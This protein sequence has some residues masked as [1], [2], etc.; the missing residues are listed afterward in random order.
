MSDRRL[1]TPRLDMLRCYEA[2]LVYW[3]AATAFA[4]PG[5]AR[6]ARGSAW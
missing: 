5:R 6:G 3:C 2:A 4:V 1:V